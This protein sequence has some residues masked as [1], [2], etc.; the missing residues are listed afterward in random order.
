MVQ[1][2]TGFDYFIPTFFLP[3]A[4][5]AMDNPYSPVEDK[6]GDRAPQS[7]GCL[8][9][10]WQ[11]GGRALSPGR[12]HCNPSALPGIQ[13]R[14]L[15]LALQDPALTHS[16]QK[17]SQSLSEHAQHTEAPGNV[18]MADTECLPAVTPWETLVRDPRHRPALRRRTNQLWPQQQQRHSPR[19]GTNGQDIED[20]T[21]TPVM[22]N[23][24]KV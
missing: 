23:T 13:G 5:A 24:L 6:G 15:S 16:P 11:Q 8:S 1:S 14:S 19:H 3:K 18:S 7:V 12:E 10:G 2:L 17:H 4:A 20:D 21:R 9:A 22:A